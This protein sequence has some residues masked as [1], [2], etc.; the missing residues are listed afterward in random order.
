MCCLHSPPHRVRRRGTLVDLD[1]VAVD[2]VGPWQ[3]QLKHTDGFVLPAGWRAADSEGC[4]RNGSALEE[5]GE[6]EW[7]SKGRG[8]RRVAEGEDCEAEG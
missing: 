3:A 1:E 8:Q 6:T 5:G 4:G 2:A 7:V